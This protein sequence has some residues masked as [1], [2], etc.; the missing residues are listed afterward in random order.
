MKKLIGYLFG[1]IWKAF[2]RRTPRSAGHL[3]F[4]FLAMACVGG[5]ISAGALPV[6]ETVIFPFTNSAFGG[7]PKSHLVIGSDGALYGTTCAF[8]AVPGGSGGGTVFKVNRDGSGFRVLH[9]FGIPDGDGIM[10]ATAVDVA[11][12]VGADNYLYGATSGG[13][14]GS[15]GTVYK[16]AQDGSIYQILHNFDS[17]NRGPFSGVILASDGALYGVGNLGTIFTLNTDGNGFKV[18]TNT[19]TGSAETALLEGHDGALYGTAVQ[20]VFKVNKDGSGYTDLHTFI[21]TDGT[22]P[23]G[24]LVQSTNDFLFGTAK[25]GG[26]AGVGTIFRLDTNGNNFQV[27]HNFSDG[28][29]PGDGSA[30]VAGLAVGPGGFFYGTT[31]FTSTNDSGNGSIFKI[32]QDGNGYEQLY[33]FRPTSNPDGVKPAASLVQGAVQGTNAVI[34]GTT[35]AAI[36]YAV[37]NGA[38]FGLIINPPLTITPVVVQSGGQTLLS[39][40]SWALNYVVQ[41]TTDLSSSNWTNVTNGVPMTSV[42]LTNSGPAAYFRLASPQ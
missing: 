42:L 26:T 41:T 34:Y 11:L 2:S 17:T 40:P 7:S 19:S 4:L 8:G 37:N 3:R 32:N 14:S 5:T 38:V 18:L 10:T 15:F 16:I 35:L 22:D 23:M 28:E 20:K 1:G 29:V 9:T 12:V 21:G 13:G 30:P 31:V 33:V 27:V 39:W 24:Q 25:T 6:L 36:G